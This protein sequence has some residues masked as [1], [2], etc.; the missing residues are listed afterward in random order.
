MFEMALA[1][2]R[3]LCNIEWEARICS[4][5]PLSGPCFMLLPCHLGNGL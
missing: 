3:A 1:A 4:A 5:H 2:G